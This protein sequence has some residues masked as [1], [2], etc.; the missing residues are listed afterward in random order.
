M[1]AGPRLT[2]GL[3]PIIRRKR[4]PL[5][6]V[7]EPDETIE[8]PEVIAKPAEVALE[9]PVEIPPAGLARVEAPPQP[10]RVKPARKKSHVP[11][12]S[13]TRQG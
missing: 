1:S 5:V 10:A 4:F 11:E 2:T 7:D 12:I 8:T 6:P 9:T 13:Q 3:Y